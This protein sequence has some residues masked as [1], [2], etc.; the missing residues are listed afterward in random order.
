[1]GYYVRLLRSSMLIPPSEFP[2]IC[3]HLLTTGFLTDTAS[4][5]GGSYTGGTKTESWYSWVNM[6]RLAEHI[7][8]NDLNAVFEEF[9]FDVFHNKDGAIE[10]LAYDNKTGNEEQLFRAMAPVWPLHAEFVWSG[11]CGAHWK[12][13]IRNKTFTVSYGIITY[14][15]E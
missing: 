8:S 11:E 10:G 1:M 12:W 4:M 14:P 3:Q 13:I 7:K 5:N 2:R 15:E 9:G 6:E